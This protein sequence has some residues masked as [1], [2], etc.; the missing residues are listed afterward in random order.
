[1]TARNFARIIEFIRELYPGE[2]TVPLHAPR[3]RG[4]EKDYLADCIDSTFVSYVGAYVTRFEEAICE[5]TGAAHAVATVN[6]TAA[7]HLALLACDVGLGD[8][9]IT[10]PLTFVGTCNG[11][12]HSGAQPCFVDVDL[13]S[14]AI[15]P[16]ALKEFLQDN[17][18]CGQDGFCYNTR[19]GRRIAACMPVHIF[20]HLARMPE[21]MDICAEWNIQ[22]IEDAAE[23]L[24]SFLDGKHSGT[25]GRVGTL[26]FNGNKVTTTGG[27]G[28]I[29]T[30]DVQLA[31]LARHISTTAKKPHP[32]AFEHDMVGYNYR[33]PNV[34]AAIGCAQMEKLPEFLADKQVTAG[35]YQK[36]F[37]ELGF[38][39]L[40]AR[41]GTDCNYW[42][43]GF[44]AADRAERDAFLALARE[45]G[46][47]A[48][49]VWT[50]M[51]HLPMYS[52]CTCGPYPNAQW[53][54]DRLV[55]V[56]SSVRLAG[57]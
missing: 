17:A 28:M 4:R 7:L 12:A 34:N 30:N 42:L 2:E 35:L 32:W 37:K 49:P 13:D 36:F 39:P 5:F 50:L 21:I 47:Q 19:T 24:G 26:S 45:S 40:T 27:G 6:G 15:S 52:H 20:G 57:S 16:T 51:P 11:I 38:Q 56:P 3:F 8:D 1:M 31:F 54:E 22:V 9:V 41:K 46:I 43:N 18:R 29:I 23:S 44:Y 14:L 25:F 55:N 53:V 10:S 33:M 48:R